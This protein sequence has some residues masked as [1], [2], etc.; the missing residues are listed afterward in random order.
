M[1][2]CYESSPVIGEWEMA[3]GFCFDYVEVLK[4]LDKAVSDGWSNDGSKDALDTPAKARA[5]VQKLLNRRFPAASLAQRAAIATLFAE[6]GLAPGPERDVANM[7]SAAFGGGRTMETGAWPYT[8]A[9]LNRLDN[10]DDASFYAQPRFVAH[11]DDR[12]IES[13]TAFYSDEF[14]AMG[15]GEDGLDVLDTCSSWISHLPTD[16]AYGRVAGL[17]MNAAELE[18][19]P[20]LTETCVRDLNVDPTLPY[21]DESFDVV[22]NVVS[23][24]Y[25]VK[26]QEFFAET[27]AVA[28]WLQ[29]DDIDKLTI[30]ASYCH[31]AAKFKEIAALDIKLPPLPMPERPSPGDMMKNPS[32][33]MAWA[34]ASAAAARANSGDPMFAVRAVERT[35]PAKSR[36]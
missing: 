30:V 22:C 24:D 32:A 28:M 20:Q 1:L 23:V 14:A 6:G 31:Y 33:A 5:A 12:A 36:K 13:L 19:N 8:A 4:T 25:L 7:S 29:A 9:D 2:D 35:K 3:C 18:K 11:I 15:A 21:D 17:G 10:S 27:K 26:P 16:A 34:S